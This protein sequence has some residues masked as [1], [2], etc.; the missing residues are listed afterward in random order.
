MTHTAVF[1]RD[2][3]VLGPERSDINGLEHHRLFR[4]VD[5]PCLVI[6]DVSSPEA[7]A[8]LRVGR[9]ADWL[10]VVLRIELDMDISLARALHITDRPDPFWHSIQ[11]GSTRPPLQLSRWSHA[12]FLLPP[13]LTA[14]VEG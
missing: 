14:S 10:V 4:R 12:T 13:L 1:D 7:W 6:H 11:G 3:N 2:F 9:R 8:G 5:N